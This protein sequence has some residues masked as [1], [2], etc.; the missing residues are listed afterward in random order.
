MAGDWIKFEHVTPDKPEVVKIATILGI[1]QD[2][3][4]GKLARLWIWADQNS[5]DGCAFSVT[6]S[7]IDRITFAT[8]FADALRKVGWLEV[9]SGSLSIPN[10]ARHNGVTAKARAES[11]RR[12]A[13]SRAIKIVK[14][15]GN[16]AENAQQKPQP[17][18]RREEY[19]H[20]HTQGSACVIPPW[21]S[22]KALA[23]NIGLPEWRA[24][25]WYD[26]MESVRWI[27]KNHRPIGKWQSALGR[28]KVWW[29]S[30]GRPTARPSRKS[31]Q[32]PSGAMADA[33]LKE[34]I[35]VKF[36]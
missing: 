18:K 33:R 23:A 16:V 2:C 1:D 12:M 7:F 15:C 29:E 32:Q 9:R 34:D 17:E 3:V 22:V 20:T 24:R 36:L 26:E 30:D 4:V 10:F 19:S 21:E 5:I 28:V 8:G 27:D 13:K 31:N 14:S 11:A 25:D 35:P 6:E